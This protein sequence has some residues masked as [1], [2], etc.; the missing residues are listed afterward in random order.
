MTKA[1]TNVDLIIQEPYKLE[2][3]ILDGKFTK[4]THFLLP[5]L[6]L[7]GNMAAFNKYF[8]NSYIN[9]EAISH[10]VSNPVFVLFRIKIFDESWKL[11][12]QGIKSSP[13]CIYEYDV[14]KWDD[15]NLVMF[16]FEFPKA[17][18]ADYF[19]FLR[20]EYSQF[21][22]HYKKLF[23]K[24]ITNDFGK[25]IE[26]PL[27]GVVYKTETFKKNLEIVI[28][29]TVQPTFEYWEKWSADREIFRKNKENERKKIPKSF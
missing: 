11:F 24:T 15:D 17:Y 25:E 29:A 16:L 7:G 3:L 28:G 18:K 27:Y 22:D 10:I 5:G 9:D 2:E 23:P 14:G 6:H 8:V 13:R 26:N 12:E 19:T 1:D 20:G 21:S 4:T